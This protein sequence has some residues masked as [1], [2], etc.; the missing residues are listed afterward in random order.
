[1]AD[2]VKKV[3]YCYTTV[4]NRAGQG[5]NVL[6]ELKGAGVDLLAYSGFPIKGGKS[7]LD[8][9]AANLS[10]LRKVAKCLPI[11]ILWDHFCPVFDCQKPETHVDPLLCFVKLS[12]SWVLWPVNKYPCVYKISSCH[13]LFL[14]S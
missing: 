7:Q 13:F 6:A 1:M 12:A 10:G 11:V 4:S 9:V 8:F 2:R 3:S 5:A 14:L